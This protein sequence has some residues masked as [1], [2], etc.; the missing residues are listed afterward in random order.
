MDAF[1][2]LRARLGFT[3]IDRLLIYG[4]GG[5]AYGHLESNSNIGEVITNP[6]PVFANAIGSVSSWQAGWTAGAGVEWAFAPHWSAKAEYL[7]YD[8][9][10]LNYNNGTLLCS[11]G[12]QC[13]LPQTISVS[14]TADFKGNIVRAGVN[15][16]FW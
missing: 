13:R 5:L 7:Y 16:R 10:D 14:S 12:G 8:L 15:Y 6:P 3:P 1:G 4:T 11:G 9:G 2:T